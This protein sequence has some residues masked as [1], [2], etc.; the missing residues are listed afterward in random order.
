MNS[1]CRFLAFKLF[2]NVILQF[3]KRLKHASQFRD[4]SALN[5]EYFWK[6]SQNNLLKLVYFLLPPTLTDF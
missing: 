6:L 5:S 3:Y 1:N 4:V 2:K